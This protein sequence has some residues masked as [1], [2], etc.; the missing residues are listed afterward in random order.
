M[1]YLQVAIRLLLA[2]LA[3]GLASVLAG[4]MDGRKISLAQDNVSN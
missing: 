2:G 3:T 4:A 1:E